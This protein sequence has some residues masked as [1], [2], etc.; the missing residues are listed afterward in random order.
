M[1]PAFA[2]FAKEAGISTEEYTTVAGA[3]SIGSSIEIISDL[4]AQP[5]LAK[6]MQGLG[7]AAVA[8]YGIWGKP[9]SARLKKELIT[10]GQHMISR[11]IDPKPSDIIA[12]RQNLEALIAGVKAKDMAKITGALLRSP[13]ELSAM[14][15][16]LGVNVKAP[17]GAPPGVPGRPEIPAIPGVPTPAP[18]LAGFP[19]P[20]P[21][22]TGPTFAPPHYTLDTVP[23]AP[24]SVMLSPKYTLDN[25]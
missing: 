7:G 15:K 13:A 9:P 1:D 20:S 23:G 12:V 5:L 18:R 25:R 3:Q 11:I 8:G 6:L 2:Y 22:A 17:L 10:L 21:V 24:V 4:F 14:L 16:A 19:F